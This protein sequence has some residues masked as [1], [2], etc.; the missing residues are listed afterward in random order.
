[1]VGVGNQ[2]DAAMI[3]FWDVKKLEN[4]S[5]SFHEKWWKRLDAAEEKSG[6]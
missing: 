4:N 3:Q 2:S 1:M 6:W 5:N